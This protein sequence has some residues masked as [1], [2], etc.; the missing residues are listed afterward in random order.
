MF[1][2]WSRNV[3]KKYKMVDGH[4]LHIERSSYPSIPLTDFDESCIWNPVSDQ[5]LKL[6]EVENP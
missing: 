1:R 2:K 5:P 4:H 3:A 6:T